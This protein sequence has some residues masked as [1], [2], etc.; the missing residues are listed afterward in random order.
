MRET[1][2]IGLQ[3]SAILGKLS[4][5]SQGKLLPF[6]IVIDD[7]TGNSFIQNPVAPEVDKFVKTIHYYR[8]PQQ[9]MSLGL[10][11]SKGLYKPD[12]TDA[13]R[14]VA[15]GSYLFGGLKSSEETPDEVSQTNEEIQL[16]RSEAVSIP[17]QCPNC[18]SIGESLTALTDIPHFKEVF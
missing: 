6:T 18:G 3:I 10:D 5:M 14:S 12:E 2:E 7:P 11:P 17:S 15:E 9:D 13:M 4:A 16:G 8:T 1:P